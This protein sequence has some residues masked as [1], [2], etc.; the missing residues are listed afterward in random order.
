MLNYSIPT[1]VHP[2]NPNQTTLNPLYD[3]DVNNC[4]IKVQIGVFEN[5]KTCNT[6]GYSTSFPLKHAIS[7]N[8]F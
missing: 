8:Q 5:H 4:T 3:D 6:I 1:V 2:S 7:P